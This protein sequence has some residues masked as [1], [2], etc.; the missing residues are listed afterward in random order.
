MTAR[1]TL[2]GMLRRGHWQVASVTLLLFGLLLMKVNL[3]CISSHRVG[4]TC[5]VM[6]RPSGSPVR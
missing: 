6:R 3:T 5:R 1:P 2:A 4:Q